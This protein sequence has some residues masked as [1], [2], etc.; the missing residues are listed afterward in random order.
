MR[1]ASTLWL[2]CHVAAKLGVLRRLRC[3]GVLQALHCRCRYTR[4][5][6]HPQGIL[7]AHAAELA[8]TC[9]NQACGQ[10]SVQS[11]ACRAGQ[12]AANSCNGARPHNRA[13]TANVTHRTCDQGLFDGASTKQRSSC[14]CE[15]HVDR[16]AG[17]CGASQRQ[18]HACWSEDRGQRNGAQDTSD[19]TL[20]HLFDGVHD[21]LDNAFDR[22]AQLLQEEFRQAGSRVDRARAATAL[23]QLGLFRGDVC[24]HGVA[25]ATLRC[26][27]GRDVSQAAFG[28]AHGGQAFNSG[29]HLHGLHGPLSLHHLHFVEDREH[30]AEELGVVLFRQVFRVDVVSVNQLLARRFVVSRVLG[31]GFKGHDDGLQLL[32]RQVLL[33]HVLPNRG[34]DRL[35]L[36]GVGHPQSRLRGVVR[37]SA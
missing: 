12:I 21:P 30:R 8:H 17:R 18:A 25:I 33:L 4:G 2:P 31:Q 23:E 14:P 34:L 24:K 15:A 1:S 20:E 9:T 19:R 26:Q 28:H 29:G 37:V 11:A 7:C 6:A 36:A 5:Q 22:P 3:L 10:A 35:L 32:R 13:A 16:R 27:V